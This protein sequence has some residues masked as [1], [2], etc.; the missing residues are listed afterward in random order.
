MYLAQEII[1]RK[2]TRVSKLG[3][4]HEFARKE[5]IV[6]LK[7]DNCLAIFS[8]SRKFMNHKRLS[9]NYFHCCNNCDYKRFAQRKGVER[10]KIWDMPVSSELNISRL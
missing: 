7:C 2:F 5:S 10:R 6:I 1:I 8:R 9:N 3:C 4:V